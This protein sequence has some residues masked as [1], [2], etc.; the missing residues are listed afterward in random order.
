M[1][2][3]TSGRWCIGQR[4]NLADPAGIIDN[5]D[6]EIATDAAAYDQ[7]VSRGGPFPSSLLSV[8]MQEP[9]LRFGKLFSVMAGYTLEQTGKLLKYHSTAIYIFL[10]RAGIT[11][12]RYGSRLLSPMWWRPGPGSTSSAVQVGL[13]EE[14]MNTEI[15]GHNIVGCAGVQLDDNIYKPDPNYSRE[16][17]LDICRVRTNQ[18]THG[19]RGKT[20]PPSPAAHELPRNRL[21]RPLT[22]GQ[23]P[24]AHGTLPA[25]LGPSGRPLMLPL[26]AQRKPATDTQ[27]RHLNAHF[28]DVQYSQCIRNPG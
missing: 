15:H 27:S 13:L 22:R 10:P 3:C 28:A 1:W 21:D 19:K 25:N 9:T 17:Q 6:A 8:G 2:G 24:C 18:P 4:A 23:V 20:S 7:S 5:A 26:I 11:W 14:F 16:Q 12:T